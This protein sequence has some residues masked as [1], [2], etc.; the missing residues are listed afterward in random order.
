MFSEK[1]ANGDIVDMSISVKK[2][3]ECKILQEEQWKKVRETSTSAIT[4]LESILWTLKDI[5]EHI[6]NNEHRLL[7]TLYRDI[8][9]DI[10]KP[11]WLSSQW[12]ENQ[13]S[14]L[15]NVASDINDIIH[16]PST[17]T[18]EEF[19]KDYPDLFENIYNEYALVDGVYRWKDDTLFLIQQ[20]LSRSSPLMKVRVNNKDVTIYPNQISKVIQKIK[21]KVNKSKKIKN[22]FIS[23]GKNDIERAIKWW[24]TLD[25]G[26]L[27]FV[28]DTWDVAID[29]RFHITVPWLK[30]HYD[31]HIWP[32]WLIIPASEWDSNMKKKME[33]ALLHVLNSFAMDGDFDHCFDVE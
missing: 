33:A 2:N 16:N 21:L 24:Y 7:D 4:T 3:W 26:N 19:I 18:C 29:K 27:S 25:H 9:Q 32:W 1:K 11:N 23:R 22:N 8:L 14:D 30:W 17:T 5:K 13:E 31:Y 20:I 15:S 28:N 12:Y 10:W 6:E